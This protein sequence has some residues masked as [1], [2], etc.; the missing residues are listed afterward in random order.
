[1]QPIFIIE[2]GHGDYVNGV[3]N[4]RQKGSKQY[5]FDDFSIYEGAINRGIKR[6]ILDMSHLVESTIIDAHPHYGGN[7]KDYSLQYRCNVLNSIADDCKKESYYPIGVSLHCNAGGGEGLEVWTSRGNTSADPCANYWHDA[8]RELV[9][10][11]KF[12]TFNHKKGKADKEANFKILND[13]NFPMFLPEHLF[14]DNK[15]EA[16]YLLTDL[17]QKEMA[18]ITIR[19][20]QLIEQNFDKIV[21]KNGTGS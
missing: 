17:G 3:Y 5:H 19:A 20:F 13:T 4:I 7:T 15:I 21:S 10:D 16:R 9:P 2:A 1:M 18:M 14:F 12:R 6:R 11:L 8:A